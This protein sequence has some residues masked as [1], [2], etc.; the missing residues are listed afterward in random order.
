MGRQVGGLEWTRSGRGHE[1]AEAVP[2]TSQRRRVGRRPVAAGEAE[3]R[4]GGSGSASVRAWEQTS[5][6]ALDERDMKGD[7]VWGWLQAGLWLLE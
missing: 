2:R 7:L 1:G 4:R 5:T 6:R 3:G